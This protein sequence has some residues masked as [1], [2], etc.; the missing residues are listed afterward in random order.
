MVIGAGSRVRL[1]WSVPHEHKK[2][3]LKSAPSAGTQL[4]LSLMKQ[5]VRVYLVHSMGKTLGFPPV[6]PNDNHQRWEPA[7]KRC[8]IVP[9]QN[10][11]LPS[12]EW[13]GYAAWSFFGSNRRGSEGTH[14]KSEKPSRKRN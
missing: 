1:E 6:L 12:A 3:R 10:G 4:S 11:W 8:G 5:R 9:E 7:A 2:R 14:Q 13:C